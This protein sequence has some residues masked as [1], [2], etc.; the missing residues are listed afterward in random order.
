MLIVHVY[1][2]ISFTI[3][4]EAAKSHSYTE[5]QAEEAIKKW[6]KYAS[7]RDGGRRRRL[8]KKK[9]NRFSRKDHFPRIRLNRDLLCPSVHVRFAWACTIT[10]LIIRMRNT[11]IFCEKNRAHKTYEVDNH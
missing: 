6:L 11:F 9:G 5:A 7:D 10:A 8:E 4:S 3:T 2:V 1:I